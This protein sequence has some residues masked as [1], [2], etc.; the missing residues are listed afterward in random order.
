MKVWDCRKFLDEKK[1]SEI[2]WE[3]QVIDNHAHL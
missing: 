2:F 3:I 1:K